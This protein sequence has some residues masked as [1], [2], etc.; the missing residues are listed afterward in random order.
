MIINAKPVQDLQHHVIPVPIP[1]EK[2]P[3]V[4]VKIP[5]IIQEPKNNVN[6]V[7]TPV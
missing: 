2:A 3:I 7:N 1:Q 6:L 5:I 4:F